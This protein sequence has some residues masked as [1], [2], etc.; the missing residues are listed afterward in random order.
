MF[1]IGEKQ[2]LVVEKMVPMGVYLKERTPETEEKEESEGKDAEHV[3]LPR[4]QVPE[5]AAAGDEVTVFLYKD[6][7][8]RLIAT[9]KEPS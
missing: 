1:R 9:R 3:L 8:D 5:G 4:T 2:T 6:S 7:E